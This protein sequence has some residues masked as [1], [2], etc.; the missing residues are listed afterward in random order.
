MDSEDESKAS[1]ES[2]LRKLTP[3]WILLIID[4]LPVVCI[5]DTVSGANWFYQG[6]IVGALGGALGAFNA[7]YLLI[8]GV[9][10]LIRRRRK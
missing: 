8:W 3:L 7:I 5:V 4:I 10:W 1:T 9:V 2:I 6:T